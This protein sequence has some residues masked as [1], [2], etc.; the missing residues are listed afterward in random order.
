MMLSKKFKKEL[1][2]FI[3]LVIVAFTVKGSIVEVYVVPTGSME[4][5]ILVGDLLFGNKWI[6]GMRT[7][8]W[9]GIPYTRIGFYIPSFRFPK[10]KNIV[11]GDIQKIIDELQ[12]ADNTEK[13][14]ASDQ[15]I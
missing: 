14:K 3:T 4:K 6:Y 15:H 5:E 10:F 8:T 7:P 2:I 11:N 13:L 12:L 9:L 1:K